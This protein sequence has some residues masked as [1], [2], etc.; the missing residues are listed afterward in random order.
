MARI[1]FWIQATGGGLGIGN[2]SDYII[3]TEASALFRLSHR[4]ML[5]AG[6]RLFNYDRTDDGINQK[7]T[8]SG[9]YIGLSIGIF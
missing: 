3:D 6:Y 5:N 8:V 2:A 4:L 7:V 1:G 9:P